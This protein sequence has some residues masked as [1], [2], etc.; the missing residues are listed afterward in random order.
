MCLYTY[1]NL[2]YKELQNMMNYPRLFLWMSHK[3]GKKCISFLK[4]AFFIPKTT[5]D[6]C[7]SSMTFPLYFHDLSLR[8]YVHHIS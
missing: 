4:T 5:A 6:L 8:A 3:Y 1:S 2:L 7:F